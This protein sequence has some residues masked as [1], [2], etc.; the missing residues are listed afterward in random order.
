MKVKFNLDWT[1]YN[2][3][4]ELIK[5]GEVYEYDKTRLDEV[6][7]SIRKQVGTFPDYKDF[8]YTVV[9]ESKETE[10]QAMNVKG[11]KDLAKER[12]LEGY[13]SLN[14]DELIEL[15]EEA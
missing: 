6:Y 12:G 15:L 9:E 1:D 5:A 14:K 2:K 3:D 7:S 10:L 13:S 4:N 11:L 8:Y